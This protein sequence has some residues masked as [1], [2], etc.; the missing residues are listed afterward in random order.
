MT[1]RHMW[2]MTLAAAC[3][4]S[5]NDSSTGAEGSSSA[6]TGS[7]TLTASGSTASETTGVSASGLGG[8]EPDRDFRLHA[9]VA[10][11]W[12]WG[13]QFVT[14]EDVFGQAEEVLATGP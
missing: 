8:H 9:H 12:C 7:A 10:S 11:Y 1:R 4:G 6:G 5:S 2:V 3:G 14:S 13:L